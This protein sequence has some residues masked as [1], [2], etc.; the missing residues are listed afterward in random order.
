[1]TEGFEDEEAM[2]K[3]GL[4][5]NYRAAREP[6]FSEHKPP[7]LAPADPINGVSPHENEQSWT[8]A[9]GG[10]STDR[11]KHGGSGGRHR[12]STDPGA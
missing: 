10:P 4:L 9:L 5:G 7:N 1:V 11:A 12:T 3:N 6:E 8:S 2:A